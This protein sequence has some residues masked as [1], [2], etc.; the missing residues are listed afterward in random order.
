M[1]AVRPDLTFLFFPELNDCFSVGFITE[2]NAIPVRE[3]SIM[4]RAEEYRR[5]AETIRSR[6]AEEQSP[7]LRAE[8]ERLAQTYVQ[9]AH[10]S[11]NKKL[12]RDWEPILATDKD[13]RRDG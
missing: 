13:D 8:W 2:R 7:L 6:A 11:G 10:Q 9:L 12:E 4:T 1:V 3:G 5:L